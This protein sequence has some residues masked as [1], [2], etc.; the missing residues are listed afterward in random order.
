MIH[1]ETIIYLSFLLH[2][3]VY[4]ILFYSFVFSLLS[5]PLSLGLLSLPSIHDLYYAYDA[6]YN[7]IIRAFV[8]ISKVV[9]VY[10]LALGIS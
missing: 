8:M 1:D 2:N 6:I 4:S 3:Y 7:S 5:T 9:M 10:S